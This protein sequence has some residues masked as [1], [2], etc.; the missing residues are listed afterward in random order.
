MDRPSVLSFV[1]LSLLLSIAACKKNPADEKKSEAKQPE[2]T[3]ATVGSTEVA[4]PKVEPVAAAADSPA[5]AGKPFT[6]VS[7]GQTRIYREACLTNIG[8]PWTIMIPSRKGAKTCDVDGEDDFAVAFTLHPC[9]DKAR[10]CALPAPGTKVKANMEVVGAF[11]GDVTLSVLRHEKPYVV[12]SVERQNGD[13]GSAGG[14][15]RILVSQDGALLV[16][17]SSW[18]E[19]DV[20][21]GAQN[22]CGPGKH[23]D[24]I[25]KKC[26]DFGDCPDGY[27]WSD[28]AH[29][30]F[31]R[32]GL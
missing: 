26:R 13:E 20:K 1:A 30:C 12:V 27:Q 17:P 19:S 14:E 21:P 25:S 29:T 5:T 2:V 23:Y 31:D 24:A 28:A 11:S 9:G 15:L 3:A 4:Q 16:D 10:K 6:V 8:A 18:K 7:R 22:K 32:R